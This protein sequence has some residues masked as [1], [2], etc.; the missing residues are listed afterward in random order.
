M[1]AR[2]DSLPALTGLRFVAAFAVF[3]EHSRE[4]FGI[5]IDGLQMLGGVAVG[6]F[7]VLSGFILT[8]VYGSQLERR[9]VPRFWL[10]RWARIWPLHV[11]CL[12]LAML[13]QPSHHV[14]HDGHAW[15]VLAS[16]V[17]L[18]QSW[19]TEGDWT[20]ALNGPAW[21]ISV[22]LFFYL[23]FPFLA[24]LGTRAFA[25]FYAVLLALTAGFI[26]WGDQWAGSDG[27]R[28]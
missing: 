11:V 1:K 25:G 21:S 12:A 27:A 4:A 24:R 13:L 28:V 20:L 8:Y 18:L 6:F 2:P 9:D 16:H 14:P 7:F 15:A 22:E 17:A 5:P 10:A 26:V 23:S 19:S 3:V